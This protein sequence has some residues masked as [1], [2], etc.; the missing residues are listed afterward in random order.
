MLIKESISY[1]IGAPVMSDVAIVA[2]TAKVTLSEIS[3][4]SSALGIGLQNAAPGD[5]PGTPN[6]SVQ[7]LFAI[8]EALNKI[9]AECDSLYKVQ[10][11]G[12]SP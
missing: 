11:Q 7:Y 4:Q 8:S 1:Q 9:A 12:T 6:N 3:R 2:A 10:S 5:K